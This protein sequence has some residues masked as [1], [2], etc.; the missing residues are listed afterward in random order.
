VNDAQRTKTERKLQ[1][2]RL[3]KN[4]PVRKALGLDAEKKSEKPKPAKTRGTA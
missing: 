3:D 2:L 1:A 4:A